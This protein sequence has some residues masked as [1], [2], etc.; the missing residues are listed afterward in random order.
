MTLS[1]NDSPF[2]DVVVTGGR[3]L[4]FTWRRRLQIQNAIAGQ[5]HEAAH[6]AVG[7][8]FDHVGVHVARAEESRA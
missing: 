6:G 4:T 3:G 7:R 5:L 2:V 8:H 1:D